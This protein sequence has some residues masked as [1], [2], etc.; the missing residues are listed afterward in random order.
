[1]VD[2]LEQLGSA[3]QQSR[4][5]LEYLPSN[6]TSRSIS[7]SQITES[8]ILRLSLPPYLAALSNAFGAG[9]YTE[10]RNSLNLYF[11]SVTRY[12]LV[13]KRHLTHAKDQLLA[14]MSRAE[15]EQG[16]YFNPVPLN[17]WTP[18][19][20][21]ALECLRELAA[22]ACDKL[23]QGTLESKEQKMLHS[24][25]SLTDY[26]Q[27]HLY[28]ED[29]SLGKLADTFQMSESSISRRIKQIT[30]C[31]FLDYVNRKRIEYACSLLSE[32]DESVNDISK[33]CGYVNDITF[34]RLFKKY[35]GI[36]P[37]DYRRKEEASH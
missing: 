20:P 24:A 37:G 29:L 10:A 3:C 36:T 31:N 25:Q 1:M 26:L 19:Q 14:A 28:D 5:A 12:G 8:G 23:E 9:Q 33:A 2:D 27:L 22:L 30:D 17:A 6:P 7:W 35:M 16:L 13:K 34:R 11:Q 21:E 4:S 32:T 18:E 15:K